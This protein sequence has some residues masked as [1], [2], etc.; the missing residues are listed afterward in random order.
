MQT[1]GHPAQRLERRIEQPL[2]EAHAAL[3]TVDT[4]RRQGLGE[5]GSN[6]VPSRL[7]KRIAR[8]LKVT[9]REQ[10]TR[11]DI[12]ALQANI[13]RVGLVIQVR[14]ILIVVLVLYS[15]IG[16][17]LYATRMPIPDLA[18][19]MWIPA[20]ALV[21]VV[22]YNTF[23]SLNYR[24][25]GNIAVWNHLQLALDAVVVTV[26]VYFSG[27][28]DS[29]F[30]SMYSLFILEATFILP[31][32]RDAWLIAGLCAL[33]LGSVELLEFFEVLPHVQIPYGRGNLHSDPVYLAVRF[34]WQIAVL[35]GTAGVANLLVGEFRRN[36]AESR[37]SQTILDATTGLLSRGYFMRVYSAEFR[38][39][40]R[41]GRPIHVLLADIDHFGRY[42]SRFGL[43][44][45][46]QLLK[47][48]ADAIT[49]TVSEA[50][51]VTASNLVARIGG[52]EFAILL[53]EDDR[54]AGPPKVEDARRL[55]ERVRAAVE[56]VEI[57]GAGVTVSLGFSTM[58]ID[59]DTPEEL[60]DAAGGT[61]VR[62]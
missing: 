3:A 16:G 44:Q 10:P 11:Y 13:R 52:E 62:D 50:G 59:G 4:H 1:Q 43:D 14:W 49:L 23:Y 8:A 5:R 31:R 33:L 53:A 58:L 29:W 7:R 48:I 60:L 47:A 32:S 46:D 61:F 51:D 35:A 19:L 36:L 40:Q 57:G 27:G 9:W 34:G 42:N 21:F 30:W 37:T 54:L 20:L 45:G 18:R 26:L 55:A 22:V 38:R 15:L 28:A 2:R 25:L 41:E 56:A 12:E 39:A 17:L 24:R 6:S